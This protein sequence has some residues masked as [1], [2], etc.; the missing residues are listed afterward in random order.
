MKCVF[1]NNLMEL[2]RTSVL[3]YDIET[4]PDIKPIRMKPYSCLLQ[5]QINNFT[6]KLKN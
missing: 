5:T 2:G 4:V 1:A 6:R 3:E